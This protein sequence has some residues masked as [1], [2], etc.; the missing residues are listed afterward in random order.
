MHHGHGPASTDALI[1]SSA[2][3][4]CRRHSRL[5]LLPCSDTHSGA[6]FQKTVKNASAVA[7]VKGKL[8]AFENKAKEAEAAE[9]KRT[10]TWKVGAGQGQYKAK[11]VIG[12]GPAP[13]KGFADLP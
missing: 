2:P 3:H 9:P 13:K 10:T 12:G 6:A 4:A 1:C 11:T 5:C 8:S 7:G